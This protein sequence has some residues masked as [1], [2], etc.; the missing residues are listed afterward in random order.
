MEINKIKLYEVTIPLK[1]PFQTH[2]G[3]LTN[4]TVI[5]VA[6]EDAEGRIGYGE[7]TAFSLPFYTSE[8]IHT[9]W[10]IIKDI[11]LPYIDFKKLSH[12][13]DFPAASEFIRGHQMA[14]A[15]VEGALWDLYSKQLNVSLSTLIGGRRKTV[16][17]GAVL[18]LSSDLVSEVEQLLEMGYERFKLKIDKG[19]EEQ[20]ISKVRDFYPELPIMIDANGMYVAEDLPT[21]KRLDKYGLIMIEQ[22]FRA[23]DFYTHQQLQQEMQTPICLD[24]S[25]ASFQDTVQALAMGSCRTVNIKISRVGGLTEAVRIHDYCKEYNIPVWCGGMVET[26]ISKAH[27]L[28]L[29]SMSN[30]TIPGDISHSTR[31]L[32]QDIISPYLEVIEGKVTVPVEAGIGVNVDNKALKTFTTHFYQYRVNES[33]I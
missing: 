1:L 24:E 17:A 4:R 32:E 33:L 23:G 12:P 30:F 31:Y 21:L 10:H 15:G 28:A 22:P 11:C 3:K 26:G 7:V 16:K 9:A 29:A 6:A 13:A 2:S 14:K 20:T 8:T 5:I 19:R 25:I 18:S 27:N